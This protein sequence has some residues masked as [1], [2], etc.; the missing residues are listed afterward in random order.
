MTTCPVHMPDAIHFA[1][2]AV[3]RT[4]RRVVCW[5]H[6]SSFVLKTGTGKWYQPANINPHLCRARAFTPSA[7]STT[8][9]KT[10]KLTINMQDIAPKGRARGP[11][12]PL[13]DLEQVRLQDIQEGEDGIR[14][15]REVT[16]EYHASGETSV[17]GVGMSE[18][19]TWR[20]RISIVMK[21]NCQSNYWVRYARQGTVESCHKIS[22]HRYM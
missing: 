22:G 12:P 7:R 19:D 1:D 9:S 18:N 2:A 13:G 21:H 8:S 17:I 14:I 6:H 3:Q 11:A 16:W 5:K 10:V 4:R 20:V 15:C